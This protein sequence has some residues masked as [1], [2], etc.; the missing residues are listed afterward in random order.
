MSQKL[1]RFH[2][3]LDCYQKLVMVNAGKFVDYQLAEDVSQETF[4]KM[5]E[6]LDFLKDDMVKQW[7][8]VV[9]GNIAKDYAKKGGSK[10]LQFVEPG[11]LLEHIAEYSESAEECFE[12]EAKQKA[13]RELIRTACSLLYEKNPDW[14]YIMIDSCI[15]GMTS[16]QIALVLHTTTKNVDV[17]K[18]RA[19]K[20]LRKMLGREYQEFF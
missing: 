10:D 17:M 15:A 7:L 8:I 11:D 19:R 16:A 6:H 14:Y 5:L 9:S 2:R 3:Y 4:I 18:C 1:E 12:R 20:Y 13:A